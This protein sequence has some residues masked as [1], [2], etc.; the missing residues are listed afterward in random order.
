MNDIEPYEII[1]IEKMFKCCNCNFLSESINTH[2]LVRI[3]IKYFVLD[4]H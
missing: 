3:V 4:I 1:L 2:L